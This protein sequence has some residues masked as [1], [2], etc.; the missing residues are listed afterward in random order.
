MTNTDKSNKFK[1]SLD[2][3]HLLST[4]WISQINNLQSILLHWYRVI[5]NQKKWLEF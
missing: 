4:N 3:I 5:S 1:I 2:N